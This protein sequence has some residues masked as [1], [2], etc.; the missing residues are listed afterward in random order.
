MD[1]LVKVEVGGNCFR[2]FTSTFLYNIV[3]F[4]ISSDTASRHLLQTYTVIL[5]DDVDP[6]EWLLELAEN[7]SAKDVKG[8]ETIY[9]D[10]GYIEFDNQA[11]TEEMTPTLPL[12]YYGFTW[13]QVKE[14]IL[15][16]LKP[17]GNPMPAIQPTDLLE[18]RHPRGS[19]KNL[20]GKI[21]PHDTEA[22]HRPQSDGGLK[23][24]WRK[25][26]TRATK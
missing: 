9:T 6:K 13:Q 19:D 25:I 16:E 1:E 24:I 3:T 10:W 15:Q 2:I 14:A 17:D 21:I 26:R 20:Y 22:I 4:G 12:S 8:R 5:S 18:F 23:E 11:N 7:N